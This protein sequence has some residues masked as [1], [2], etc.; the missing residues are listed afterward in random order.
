MGKPAI[1]QRWQDPCVED[2][3]LGLVLRALRLRRGLSQGELAA[4][5]RV[6][7]PTVSRVERGHVALLSVL[8]VRDLFTAVD[9]LADIDVRWRGGALDRLVDERH[10]ALVAAAATVMQSTGWRVLLEVT[11]SVFG[12]RGSID[13]LGLHEA[14]RSA[15][16]IEAKT[17][18]TSVEET[19]RRMDVKA[20]LLPGIVYERVGWRPRQAARILLLPEGRTARRRIDAASRLM[21]DTLPLRSVAVRRW[22]E[23]PVG[24]VGGIWFLAIMLPRNGGRA[25]G[26]LPGPTCDAR[27]APTRR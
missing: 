19:Q 4:L 22:M 2:R 13:L 10:A 5:A 27:R 15:A 12:E 1:R 17:D 18:I 26:R 20:R 11:F 25:G 24:A 9:A 3:R 6:S 8:S 23:E 21:A 14:T 16:M 7:Q